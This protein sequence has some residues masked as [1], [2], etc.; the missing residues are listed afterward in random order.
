MILIK[1]LTVSK[2]FM[3]IWLKNVNN[4]NLNQHC[5]KSLIGDYSPYINKNVK[6]ISN[7]ELE[8]N[9]YYLC[10]VSK[11]YNWF[12]NFHLAFKYSEGT[13]FT[14]ENNGISV[15][16]E[17]AIQL[18]ISKDYIDYSLPKAHLKSYNT[19]RNWWFANYFKSHEIQSL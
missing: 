13:S 17:N 3:Y 4:V 8:D 11:P 1:N 7:L 10:G 2:P 6:E 16:I 18:P 19:C 9:I 15:E 14:Y 12:N 5:A